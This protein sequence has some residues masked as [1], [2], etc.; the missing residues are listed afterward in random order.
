MV[1][2]PRRDDRAVR[3]ERAGDVV[4]RLARAEADLLG[5]DVDRVAAEADHGHLGRRA[6]AGPTASR[7]AA[8]TPWP[9]STCGTRDGSRFQR[10]RRRARAANSAGVRS[11]TSRKSCGH[12]GVPPRSTLVEDRDRGV[13]LVVGHEQRRRE[14]Q[15]GRG[16][17][18]H[19]P[20]RR[21]G[22]AARRPGRVDAGRELGRE[23]Q[24]G[25]AH[26]DDARQR[27]RAPSVRR[28]PA[29]V[30]SAGASSRFHHRRA[31]RARRGPRAAGRRTSWRG[32]RA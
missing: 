22:N 4:D 1:E 2:H 12:H 18:V 6:G 8:P 7:T 21:R 27:Q 13:D 14:A 31:P 9:S 23:Q 26:V 17:R 24:P 25:A 19:A 3:R 29:R 28:S 32:R 30:A 16:D 20:A 5:P 11:S 10:A 15:R